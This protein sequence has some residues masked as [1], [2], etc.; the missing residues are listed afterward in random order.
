MQRVYQALAVLAGFV[1]DG[2][3][4][5]LYSLGVRELVSQPLLSFVGVRDL[6]LRRCLLV[7][8]KFLHEA[9]VEPRGA[10]IDSLHIVR[11]RC[12]VI[13]QALG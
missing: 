12:K 13:F 3:S 4:L 10:I 7:H 5:K 8:P 2:S 11:C 9:L 1:H 6:F